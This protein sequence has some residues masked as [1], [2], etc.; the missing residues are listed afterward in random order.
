MV[1]FLL[2][3]AMLAGAAVDSLASSRRRSAT[4]ALG[5]VVSLVALLAINAMVAPVNPLALVA[6]V[7]CCAALLAALA[8]PESRRPTILIIP[9]LIIFVELFVVGRANLAN[10]P[11]GGF[12][13]VDL[14][15]YYAPSP[16]AA[17]LRTRIATAP[18]PFRFFGYDPGVHPGGPTPPLYRYLFA[19]P[20]TAALAV[21][22]R[23]TV[24]ELQDVQGYNPIQTQRYVDFMQAANDFAQEYH[25]ANVYAGGVDSPLLDMLNA[26][27]IIV[28]TAIP[29]GRPDLN[30]LI[31]RHDTVFQDESVRILENREALP[32][33][34]LVHEAR[35]ER[36]GDA[37]AALASGAVDP[38]RVALIEEEPPRLAMPANPTADR[39]RVTHFE[40][41]ELRVEVSTEAPAMLVL[42]EMYDPNWRA[43]VDGRAAS[44]MVA[45]Y[46]LR[47]VVVPAGRHVVEMWYS[48]PQ[49]TWG[50]A[51][52]MLGYAGLVATWGS[53]LDR[54][55]RG[56]RS[57]DSG[58]GGMVV[59]SAV[60]R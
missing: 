2:G 25:E 59:A 58:R 9:S 37:L 51:A 48:S 43:A 8:I 23:A 54:T 50:S 35:R 10:G 16:A 44:V 18:E 13:K 11:Y 33:A 29:P 36:P 46:T 15:S 3:P 39:A 26:R 28:P 47:A 6:A 1:A 60:P 19:D 34:W 52:T 30:R 38:R 56:R 32:R 21:N 12:H 4:A 31:A 42:S 14:A 45:D 7:L 27:F 5:V 53:A 22:N 40:P 20:R 55:R 17:L 57:S 24:L 49:L 41:D